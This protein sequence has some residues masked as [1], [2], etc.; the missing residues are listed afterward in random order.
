MELTLLL[1]G[2]EGRTSTGGIDAHRV[3]SDALSRRPRLR[4][5][6]GR[7]SLAMLVLFNASR[8]DLPEGASGMLMRASIQTERSG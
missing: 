2:L 7:K 4:I 1:L 6:R 8:L 3:L 5:L